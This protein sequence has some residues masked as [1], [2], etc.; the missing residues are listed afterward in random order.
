MR[1]SRKGLYNIWLQTIFSWPNLKYLQLFGKCQQLCDTNK[2]IF[3]VYMSH[4]NARIAEITN[5]ALT[6]KY[7]ST[8]SYMNWSSTCLTVHSMPFAYL[9]FNCLLFFIFFLLSSEKEQQD[10][11][12]FYLFGNFIFERKA[13]EHVNPRRNF[14]RMKRFAHRSCPLWVHYNWMN[15]A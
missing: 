6:N 2:L 15:R 11:V 12:Y 1:Q 5:V 10:F 14:K 3:S 4:R 13:L 8:N 9:S 7:S